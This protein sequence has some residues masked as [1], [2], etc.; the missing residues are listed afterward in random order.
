MFNFAPLLF[1]TDPEIISH[2]YKHKNDVWLKERDSQVAVLGD[3]IATFNHGPYSED[4]GLIYNFSRKTASKMFSNSFLQRMVAPGALNCLKDI[5]SRIRMESDG[6][7]TLEYPMKS[8]ICRFTFNLIAN[9]SFGY[10][11][12]TEEE[13]VKFQESFD[14]IKDLFPNYFINPFWQLPYAEK[15]V[16]SL[17]K[18]NAAKEHIYNLCGEIIDKRI[19]LRKD[20]E[21]RN[22]DILSFFLNVQ[23]AD[24][25]CT[26]KYLRDMVFTFIAGGVDTGAH[27]MHFITYYL[28]KDQTLQEELYKMISKFATI[29][30]DDS[31]E[32]DLVQLRSCKLLDAIVFETLRI[33]CPIPISAR[34]AAVDDVLPDGNL[35]PR[36]T[37]IIT[38]IYSMSR[39][40]E[41][42][43]VSEEFSPQRWL[44]KS[45][46]VESFN[47]G[48]FPVFTAGR[49]ICIG[50]DLAVLEVKIFVACMI[51]TFKWSLSQKEQQKLEKKDVLYGSGFLQDFDSELLCD[52]VLRQKS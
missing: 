20:G 39:N 10:K 27:T 47:E 42:W 19:E 14:S 36:G 51:L 45:R 18:F 40:N 9:V 21:D 7:R 48:K 4:K 29:N 2:V 35:I 25:Y 11:F 43:K 28:A 38:D 1:T 17:R 6:E 33:N 50:K 15:F 46:R 41:T 24:K 3:S 5:S 22:A 30:R 13:R 37:F 23:E 12:K 8:E 16:S 49:R 26:K 32:I 52:F 31:F 34:Y 44:N